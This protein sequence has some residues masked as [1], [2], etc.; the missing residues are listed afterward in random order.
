MPIMC[1]SGFLKNPL[2]L[3]VVDRLA[4]PT[5]CTYCNHLME[6]SCGMDV[7]TPHLYCTGA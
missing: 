6:F 7:K 1:M 2:L 3:S 5:A 4:E